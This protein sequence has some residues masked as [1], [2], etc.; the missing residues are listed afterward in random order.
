[1]LYKLLKRAKIKR[2]EALINIEFYILRAGGDL[3]PA[4]RD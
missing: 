3:H 4:K 1:M 2:P